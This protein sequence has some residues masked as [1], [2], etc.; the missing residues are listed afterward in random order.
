FEKGVDPN[1]TLYAL[2]RATQLIQEIAGGTIASKTTD[3]YPQ[4]IT[5]DPI[6]VRY[7]RVNDL[8]GCDIPPAK[9]K[10]IFEALNIQVLSETEEGLDVRVPTDKPDVLREVDVIEEILRIY[11][12]NEV[13]MSSQIRSSVTISAKPDPNEVRQLVSHYLAANGFYEM[14]GLSL[15]QSRYCEEVLPVPEEQRVYVANTSNSHLDIMRPNMIFNGLEAIQHNK[16]RQQKDI[17]LFEFGNSYLKKEDDTFSEQSHLTIWMA[18]NQQSESWHQK[19]EKEEDFFSLKAFVK[20]VL[21]RMG[22]SGFQESNLEEETGFQMG[23]SIHRGPKVLARYGSIAPGV[24]NKMDVKGPV[25]FADFDWKALFKALKKQRV[26][27]QSL[28]KFPSV[29]RDL[30]LVIENSVKFQDIEAI[31]RK[32]GKKLLRDV[33]LFDVYENEEQLGAGKKSYAISLI[34]QDETKTLKDKDV[35]QLI[36]KLIQDYESKLGAVIRR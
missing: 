36:K 15:T 4:K 30:A 6:R 3:H 29:R 21:E 11:G 26:D 17:R 24:C 18:G 2:H 9:I 33:N 5:A 13:P 28:T 10:E 25:Y 7:Q 19:D 16:N 1:G 27:F 12:L 8:I 31:A 35:D 23:R 20:G 32:I 14:M 34:F 22:I